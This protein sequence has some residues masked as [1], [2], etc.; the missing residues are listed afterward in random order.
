MQYYKNKRRP[1]S[2]RLKDFDYSLDGAYFI[3][4]CTKN[5]EHFFGEIYNGKLNET[6]QS[7]ICLNCWLDLPNHYNNCIVDEFI[8]MPDHIHGIIFI[9]NP[10]AVMTGF[11]VGAGLKP[12]PTGHG[13]FK[14]YSVSEIIRGFKT[15]TARKI[16]EY[17]NMKDRA[18]WQTRFYDHIIENDDELNRIRKYI[19]NNPGAWPK[20]G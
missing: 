16:N 5:R 4:I 1:N 2:M 8:V 14:S 12:A 18:L 13:K 17:E 7:K 20:P 3:T 19:I 9:K 6:E 15:F 11:V 10:N